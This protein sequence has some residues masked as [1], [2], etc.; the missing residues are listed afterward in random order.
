MLKKLILVA[1]LI[2][3]MPL[4][5]QKQAELFMVAKSTVADISGFCDRNPQVCQKGHAALDHLATKAE[6][7]A[8][9]MLDIAREHTDGKVDQVAQLLKETQ[10]R[11]PSS[12]TELPHPVASNE[13]FPGYRDNQYNELYGTGSKLLPTNTLSPHDLAPDWQGGAQ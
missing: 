6:F 13:R 12:R 11:S 7:S 3:V 4:D 2:A 10:R 8:K 1:A 5:R 9:M